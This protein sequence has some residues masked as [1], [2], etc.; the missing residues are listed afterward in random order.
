MILSGRE[1]CSGGA[2]SEVGERARPDVGWALSCRSGSIGSSQP[3]L[4][5]G[6]DGQRFFDE[7]RGLRVSAGDR[8]LSGPHHGGLDGQHMTRRTARRAAPAA[9]GDDG[10][11][12]AASS[13]TR[14]IGWVATRS[15]ARAKAARASGRAA[16]PQPERA[17]RVP[18]I[19]A[20]LARIQVAGRLERELELELR[21]RAAPRRRARDESV[22]AASA[23]PPS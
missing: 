4:P 16:L 8:Q 9:A 18:R 2:V 12:P 19:G 3:A 1:S 11:P 15:M 6:R 13:P 20:A 5:G 14:A 17:D 21:E 10:S 7:A 22:R 23:A